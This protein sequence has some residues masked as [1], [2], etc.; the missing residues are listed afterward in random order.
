MKNTMVI[1]RKKPMIYY[2]MEENKLRGF[3]TFYDEYESEI[4][5]LTRNITT[6]NTTKKYFIFDRKISRDDLMEMKID[7]MPG[8]RIK[9]FY[10]KSD[11]KNS[12]SSLTKKFSRYQIF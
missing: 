8:F 9:W 5:K 1:M 4:N 11:P 3:D 6:S 2:E 7:S 12:D 10:E